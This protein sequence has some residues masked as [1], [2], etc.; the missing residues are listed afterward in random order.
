MAAPAFDP[1]RPFDEIDAPPFDPSKPFDDVTPSGRAMD[2]AKSLGI[3]AAKGAIGMAGL[4]GDV[5][6]LIDTG[7]SKLDRLFGRDPEKTKRSLEIAA[8]HNLP[9][10]AGIRQ[11]VEGVTGKFY[12]PQTT[13]GHY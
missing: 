11:G 4:P 6:S 13:A 3:G 1:S 2:V 9:T 12:E 7:F 10:S 5:G 8:Q